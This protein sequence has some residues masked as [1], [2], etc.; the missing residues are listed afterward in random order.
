[1]TSVTL[2]QADRSGIESPTIKL[3]DQNII[4][5]L[6]NIY[7]CAECTAAYPTM[8]SL[9]SHFG[10]SHQSHIVPC[11]FSQCGETFLNEKAAKRHNHLYHEGDHP[12]PYNDCPIR[13]KSREILE[14]HLRNHPANGPGSY[15]LFHCP[16]PDCEHEFRSPEGLKFHRDKIHNMS[17]VCRVKGCRHL[18][19][20]V[21]ERE[22]H[23]AD[24][25]AVSFQQTQFVCPQAE[26]SRTFVSSDELYTHFEN[27]RHILYTK[28][29][30]GK[31]FRCAFNFCRCLL[32]DEDQ[33]KI[34]HS[35][36]HK[37]RQVDDS[38]LL[39][40]PSEPEDGMTSLV[41]FESPVVTEGVV[42]FFEEVLTLLGVETF[43]SVNEVVELWEHFFISDNDRKTA[44]QQLQ[45]VNLQEERTVIVQKL[46]DT[47]LAKLISE[48]GNF[49]LLFLQTPRNIRLNQ[50]SVKEVALTVLNHCT[51]LETMRD[52]SIASAVSMGRDVPD[53][54]RDPTKGYGFT[55]DRSFAEIL[56]ALAE[57]VFCRKSHQRSVQLNELMVLM[58][59]T[60]YLRELKET[61][62]AIYP[63]VRRTQ[64]WLETFGP[65]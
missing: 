45:E 41:S 39:K 16:V 52:R 23:F 32:P 49:K 4:N 17:L 24:K 25:H 36:V 9:V 53:Q 40:G 50:N 44:M 34:H 51:I 28:G 38:E 12:C 19:M 22:N 2:A 58:E 26:C 29:T 65:S 57:R 62:W 55:S 43:I 7:Q 48:W 3:E 1:M 10:H 18:S 37:A 31:P 54:L 20:S 21:E 6:E 47:S 14:K 46:K 56:D 30:P 64:A 35:V 11:P 8:K 27:A 59:M 61:V 42:H 60:E 13:C 15:K 63:A 33:M 5:N